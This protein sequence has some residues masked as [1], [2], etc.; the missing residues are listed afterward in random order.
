M[1]GS[2]WYIAPRS[3]SGLEPASARPSP[4]GPWPAP[5]RFSRNAGTEREPTLKKR[6]IQR[7]VLGQGLNRSVRLLNRPSTGRHRFMAST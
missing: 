7:Y 5:V 1:V 3:H 2:V 4:L 6:L